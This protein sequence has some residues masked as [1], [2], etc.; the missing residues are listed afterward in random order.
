MN[1]TRSGRWGVLQLERVSPAEPLRTILLVLV[2]DTTFLRRQTETSPNANY[3]HGF[4]S[5][6]NV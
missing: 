2:L 5:A 1:E 6:L 3:L 4:L